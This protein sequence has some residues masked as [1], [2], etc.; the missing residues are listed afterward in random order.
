[1]IDIDGRFRYSNIIKLTHDANNPLTIFPN[2]ATD[3]ITISGLDGKGEIEIWSADGKLLQRENVNAQ[4][5]LLNLKKL[6]DGTYLLRYNNGE[7]IFV[8]RLLIQH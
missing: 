1:M 2:P 7:N 4:T 6:I 8:H 5:Q 3:V